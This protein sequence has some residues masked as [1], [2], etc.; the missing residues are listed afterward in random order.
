PDT[1]IAMQQ[2]AAK[3]HVDDSILEYVSQIVTATRGDRDVMLGV[4]M[5]GAL[6]LT[7]AA[8]T[9]AVSQGRGYVTPDDVREL[10]EPVL[11]HRIIVDPESEFA[12]TS[13][14]DIVGRIL[15]D[16]APPQYRTA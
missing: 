1:V 11:A 6:A 14:A 13:A 15:I 10:A 5:R 16:I 3:V 7:R 8:R 2:L 4:S 9:W 12:G